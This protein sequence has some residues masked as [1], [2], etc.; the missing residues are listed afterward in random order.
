MSKHRLDV[1]TLDVATFETAAPTGPIDAT[2]GMAPLY[3]AARVDDT[4]W[5]DCTYTPVCPSD[6]TY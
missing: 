4:H 3:A 2:L 5:R 6:G 1:E